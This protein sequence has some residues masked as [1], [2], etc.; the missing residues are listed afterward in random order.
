[1]ITA[2][3]TLWSVLPMGL[4]AL[5]GHRTYDYLNPCVAV[6]AVCAVVGVVAILKKAAGLVLVHNL[7]VAL[8]FGL[9]VV[10][11]AHVPGGDD[12]AG[13]ILVGGSGPTLLASAILAMVSAVQILRHCRKG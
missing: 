6:L 5:R 7:F 1:M 3:F 2:G 4:V 12:G 13:M 8:A 10:T 9:F 11:L